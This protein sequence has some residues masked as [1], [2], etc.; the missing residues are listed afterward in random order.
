MVTTQE[1]GKWEPTTK[2]IIWHANA[3]DSCNRKW[4]DQLWTWKCTVRLALLSVPANDGAEDQLWSP[5]Q[6]IH[7]LCFVHVPGQPWHSAS[8]DHCY[9]HT[10]VRPL[11]STYHC[12]TTAIDIPLYGHCYRHTIVRPLLSTY[13]C[14]TTAIDIPLYMLNRTSCAL[15]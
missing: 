6:S 8:Y 5:Y 9:R 4:R 2:K 15:R 11:L 10:I 3:M 1:V 7:T 14:T 12:T 13:H